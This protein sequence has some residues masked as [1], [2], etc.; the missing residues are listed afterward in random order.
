MILDLNKFITQGQVLW[1]ELED[2]LVQLEKDP[3]LK[4]EL[5]QLERF[6]YLYQRSSADLARLADFSTRQE[7]RIYLESL[8]ARS[9]SLIHKPRRS[10][11]NF[12]IWTW[13]F[14][15]FPLTFRK[16]IAA[17]WVSFAILMAG[18]LFGAA[19]IGLD[20]ES[21]PALMP[22]AHLMQDP[23]QRVAKEETVTK[24]KIAGKKSS[25]A[26]YLI[27]NNTRV[28]FLALSLGIT[29]GIGTILVLFSN[30]V[31]L[32]ATIADYILAGQTK[33]L[34]GWLLPHGSIELPAIILAAQAGLILAGALIGPIRNKNKI[35]AV[36][37]KSRFR[38]IASDLFTLMGGVCLMLVWAGFIEAFLSQYH[39]P[40]ISYNTKILFGTTQLI[41][42]FVFLFLSG[43]P[44]TASG[45]GQHI[46]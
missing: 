10:N 24:D 19:A 28:A 46:P 35:R 25:F 27:S 26:S 29:W 12:K 34:L 22:F 21:K 13:F 15:S 30:G 6:H 44:K 8:V 36:S 1:S 40:A 2:F 16:H 38:N 32:G 5:S 23:A 20:S 45:K 41:V 18:T 33:F 3:N 11:R 14:S 31:Y 4:L 39:E 7:I 43:R 37:L 17:F 42:L 9:F